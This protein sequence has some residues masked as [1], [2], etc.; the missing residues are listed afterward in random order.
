V[1]ACRTEQLTWWL[2]A[3]LWEIE[4]AGRIEVAVQGLVASR[5][6]L[7]QRVNGWPEVGPEL[8]AWAAWRS[9]DAAVAQLRVAQPL[10]DAATPDQLVAVVASLAPDPTTPAGMVLSL[11]ADNVRDLPNPVTA[12]HS[13]AR[14]GGLLAA[15]RSDA[16]TYQSGFAAERQAQSQWLSQRLGLSRLPA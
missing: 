8:A 4:L 13:S 15:L 6:R 10:G 1:H 11:V 5:G 9:R 12:C 16:G 14:L 7:V 3:Q 2:G